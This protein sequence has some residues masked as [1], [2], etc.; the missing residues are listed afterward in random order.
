MKIAERTSRELGLIWL[1]KVVNV[2][3]Q[4]NISIENG[5]FD[6]STLF[7]Q[8]LL[9][10]GCCRIIYHSDVYEE[11]WR[12]NFLGQGLDAVMP[13]HLFSDEKFLRV[14]IVPQSEDTFSSLDSDLSEADED[15]RCFQFRL[16][17]PVPLSEKGWFVV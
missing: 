17:D 6:V 9:P 7:S 8:I 13:D 15:F 11:S 12:C 10:R 16:I 4:S 5:G 2:K 3:F 14:E 1:E